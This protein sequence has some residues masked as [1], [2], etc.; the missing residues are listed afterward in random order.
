MLHASPG[1]VTLADT[2]TLG[3]VTMIAEDVADRYLIMGLENRTGNRAVIILTRSF[4]NPGR[5]F[6]NVMAFRAPWNR[7]TRLGLF[8]ENGET[9]NKLLADYKAGIGPKPFT[10]ERRS[11]WDQGV[12]FHRTYP[13]EA[14]IE[15]A[16]FSV[17]ESFLGGGSCIGGGG[18]GGAP[19]GPPP[20]VRMA[21]RGWQRLL[22]PST[23]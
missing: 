1:F 9:R 8:G 6:A 5:T 4:L 23:H 20:P 19:G 2:P 21:R 15:L 16:A 10:F 7:D 14:P 17:Y 22:T 3:A 18:A 11:G 12:E 13:K